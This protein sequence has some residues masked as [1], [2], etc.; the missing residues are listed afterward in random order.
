[1]AHKARKQQDLLGSEHDERATVSSANGQQSFGEQV[2]TLG[3][4]TYH[5]KYA[6]VSA[7]QDCL[8]RTMMPHACSAVF[9]ALAD[10]I[11][12]HSVYQNYSTVATNGWPVEKYRYELGRVLYTIEES[13]KQKVARSEE[14]T[15]QEQAVAASRD[16]NQQTWLGTDDELRELIDNVTPIT[17]CLLQQDREGIFHNEVVLQLRFQRCIGALEQLVHSESV[18]HWWEH[19]A[20]HVMCKKSSIHKMRLFKPNGELRP[21]TYDGW[22]HVASPRLVKDSIL[23]LAMVNQSHG[24]SRLKFFDVVNRYFPSD[25]D[26]DEDDSVWDVSFEPMRLKLLSCFVGAGSSSSPLTVTKED[27]LSASAWDVFYGVHCLL[28]EYGMRQSDGCPDFSKFGKRFWKVCEKYLENV[29]VSETHLPPNAA[30][31]LEPNPTRL[32][33]GGQAV[34][35]KYVRDNIRARARSSSPT[36]DMATQQDDVAEEETAPPQCYIVTNEDLL[37]H[38]RLMARA[39]R[40]ADVIIRL[41]TPND[42]RRRITDCDS[43]GEQVEFSPAGENHGRVLN[44]RTSP[45]PSHQKKTARQRMFERELEE[46]RMREVRQQSSRVEVQTQNAAAAKGPVLPP[47]TGQQKRRRW[48]ANESAILRQAVAAYGVGSW[49]QI[50]EDPRFSLLVM[51]RRTNVNLKDRWRSMC[52]GAP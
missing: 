43:E 11:D 4:M 45:A 25:K 40:P 37:E 15:A 35:S 6:C 44:R 2:F 12:N 17:D 7:M 8:L 33:D 42:K 28:D 19:Y 13:H 50:L 32:E 49:R 26:G 31:G 5:N 3:E 18:E 52:R 14:S 36:E 22:N 46:Q 20:N 9:G 47:S 23:S 10:L 21:S 24:S 51:N 39:K 30:I 29:H 1:M 38:D 27:V 16:Q 41:H 48:D 34:P